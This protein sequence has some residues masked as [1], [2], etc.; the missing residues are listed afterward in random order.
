MV[1]S[2]AHAPSVQGT[3]R[4]EKRFLMLVR[5]TSDS[6]VRHS[7]PP[8]TS[9]DVIQ[10]Q[11]HQQNLPDWHLEDTGSLPP[12]VGST[13]VPFLGLCWLS[14]L[15]FGKFWCD[16]KAQT[17]LL[18]YWGPNLFFTSLRLSIMCLVLDVYVPRK[19]L[20]FVKHSALFSFCRLYR[21]ENFFMFK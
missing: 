16:V 21:Q 18:F 3:I 17:L 9:H 7:S 5:K 1:S 15:C 8:S 10:M 4:Y 12:L 6:W 20:E 2:K 13:H 19:S 11:N 14:C